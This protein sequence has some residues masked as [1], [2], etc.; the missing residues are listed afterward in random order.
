MDQINV[1]I[2]EEFSGKTIREILL[3]FHLG[4]EKIYA[5][6]TAK[7]FTVNGRNVSQ[8]YRCTSGETLLIRIH[9]TIGVAPAEEE[10]DIAYEDD[11]YIFVNKPRGLLV[12]PDGTGAESLANRVAA[13]YK[14]YHIRRTVR[15]CNRLDVDTEGLVAVAKDPLAE[16]FLN[17]RI[18]N[19][20]VE[21]RYYALCRNR[22]SRMSGTVDLPIGR[23]LHDARRMRVSRTGKPARTEYRVLQNGSVSL[24]EVIP[25]TGRT[26]QIRVHMAHMNHPLLG[27]ELYGG[28]SEETGLAL[29]AHSF[30]FFHPFQKKEI[31]VTVPASPLFG[32]RSPHE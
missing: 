22:F 16:A 17:D 4:K 28:Q 27:D 12:H 29:Q 7:A 1:F 10:A 11:H 5:Y 26:H 13:Y 21:K 25:H 24:V 18:A 2:D 15:F 9:E 32:H 30:R 3:W 20:A 6:E 23:D 19:R 8:R 14:K 31:T